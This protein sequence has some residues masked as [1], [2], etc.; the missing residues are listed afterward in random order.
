MLLCVVIRLMI[1]RKCCSRRLATTRD[2]GSGYYDSE[3]SHS[4]T[5]TTRQFSITPL[6]SNSHHDDTR[7]DSPPPSYEQAIKHQKC[8]QSP[9]I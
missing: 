1:L 6:T 4:H 3:Q 7:C 9:S 2:D 5:N 8:L